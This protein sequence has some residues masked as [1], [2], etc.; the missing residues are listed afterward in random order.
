MWVHY[1]EA[2]RFSFFGVLMF[3]VD[4]SKQA[5]LIYSLRNGGN[6]GGGGGRAELVC[7][8]CFV[9]DVFYK[10]PEYE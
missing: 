4:M 7:Y 1:S 2:R 5:H 9:S 3:L 8:I 10:M 6:G